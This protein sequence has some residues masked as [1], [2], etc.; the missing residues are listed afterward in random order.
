MRRRGKRIKICLDCGEQRTA[1]F[2]YVA[3]RC[4]PCASKRNFA[5]GRA[6]RYARTPKRM[7]NCLQCGIS[8]NS[9]K[10]ANAKYCSVRCKNLAH[11]VERTCKQCSG[12]FIAPK[13]RLNGKTNSTANFCSRPCYNLFLCEP[14]KAGSRGP[15]WTGAR[16]EALRRNP[17]CAFCGKFSHLHVHH[18][19]PYRLTKD[20]RQENLIPLCRRHHKQL[21]YLDLSTE[22]FEKDDLDLLLLRRLALIE[23]QNV[24][25][26]RLIN[27]FGEIN[28]AGKMACG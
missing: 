11:Q 23:Y 18:I 5:L 10:T 7:I 9:C 15:G 2:D 28:E 3:L 19:V 4:R 22:K 8:F 27:L 20:N 17:F 25:R 16:N 13:S 14:E 12:I 1:R 24:T 6:I 21:E 26:L